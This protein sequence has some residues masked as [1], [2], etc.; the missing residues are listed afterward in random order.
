MHD[1]NL[2]TSSTHRIRT[3]LVDAHEVMQIGISHVLRIYH[4]DVV[5]ACDTCTD[6]VRLAQLYKPDLILMEIQLA[7]GPTLEACRTIRSAC[8]QA[9][10]IFLTSVDCD[11]MRRRCL[12][13]GSH[14]YLLNSVGARELAASI[15]ALLGRKN[16][17]EIEAAAPEFH[18]LP[19]SATYLLLSPQ[20][21]KIPPL[22][23]DGKT[24]KEIAEILGL[25]DK[26]VKNYLSNIY[27]KLQVNRRSQLAAVYARNAK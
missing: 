26:T 9:Q 16:P 12:A 7:D 25:S 24:N 5:D 21:R 11:E 18:K 13:A 2:K 4:I 14:G 22:I 17:I 19:V 23:A 10:V 6:A 8:P 27:L 3:L 15:H 1:E 20:E